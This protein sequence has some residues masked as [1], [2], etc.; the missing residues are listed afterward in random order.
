MRTNEKL[1]KAKVLIEALS[2]SYYDPD[3]Q[4]FEEQ[5]ALPILTGSDRVA[6]TSKLMQVI[7]SL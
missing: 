7:K 6:A 2:A 5:K 4:M 3:S 1:E